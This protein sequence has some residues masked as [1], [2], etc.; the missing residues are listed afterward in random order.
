ME[1]EMQEKSDRGNNPMTGKEKAFEFHCE[2]WFKNPLSSEH[3][4]ITQQEGRESK[5]FIQEEEIA[6]LLPFI[7]LVEEIYIINFN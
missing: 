3:S 4:M 6:S 1:I 5:P 7:G 2:L